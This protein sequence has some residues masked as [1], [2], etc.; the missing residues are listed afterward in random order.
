MRASTS[1]DVFVFLAQRDDAKSATERSYWQGYADAI[2][3]Q[4][5]LSIAEVEAD[6]QQAMALARATMP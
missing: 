2:A 3:D 1:S 4:A 5:G 6:Y